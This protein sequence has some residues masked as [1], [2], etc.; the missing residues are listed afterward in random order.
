M[1]ALLTYNTK[2]KRQ[3]ILRIYTKNNNKTN[4]KPYRVINKKKFH[5]IK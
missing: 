3:N 4:E 2:K 1:A 5:F